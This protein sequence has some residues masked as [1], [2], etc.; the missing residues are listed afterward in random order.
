MALYEYPLSGVEMIQL[1]F[2]EIGVI[3][4]SCEGW[5]EC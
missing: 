2:K 1:L 3:F 4:M 5:R